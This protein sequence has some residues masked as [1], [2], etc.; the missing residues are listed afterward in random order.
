M[1]LHPHPQSH[2]NCA[3]RFTF[4]EIQLATQNLD[5]SLVIG[6]G[7][8]GKVYK[9]TIANGENLLTVAIKRLDA[10]SNQGASEF[11]AEVNML[12]KLRHCHLVSLIGYCNDGKEMILVYE[13]M[14][15]GTLEDHLHCSRI[16]LS[17][18]Q[19]LT[20]CI[21][22]ARG[23]DYLHTGTGI[24]HGVVHRDVKSSN[25]LLH[26]DWA[27][28]I[29]DFG[30]SKIC[31]KNQ[32]TTHVNTNVKG[33]FGYLD[34]DYFY[35]GKLTR[36]S[37]VYAFG[38]VLFEVLCGKRA[39]DRRIDEE[40]WGLAVWAQKSIK[41]GR[42][43]EIVDDNIR[44]VISP[45]CLKVFAEI[46]KRCLH[47]QPKQRPTMAEVVI[48]LESVLTL[49]EKANI[50]LQSTGIKFFASK[51]AKAIFL[52]NPKYSG[53]NQKLHRFDFDT[54][55][56]ATENFSDANRI[57]SL[58]TYGYLYKGKLQNGQGIAVCRT[59]YTSSYDSFMNE[60]SLVV[61]LEH[62][63][64]AKLLG[65]CYERASLI[66]VYESV[67][68]A[69]PDDL[70]FD[71]VGTHLDWDKRFK[72]IL[73]VA[74]ALLYL[75]SEAPIR[76]IHGDV[77]PGNILLD[78]NMN[79]VLSDYMNTR[80]E[81]YE[82][83]KNLHPTFLEQF[84]Y[85]APEYLPY[86]KSSTK[87]DV[88]SFGVLVLE[89]ITGHRMPDPDREYSIDGVKRA[90]LEVKTAWL[91]G[92]L[93]NII[94]PKVDVDPSYMTSFFAIGLLCVQADPADRPTMEE[95]VSMLLDSSALGLPVAKLQAIITRDSTS[96]TRVDNHN[97][98]TS[99][100]D[101]SFCTSDDDYDYDNGIV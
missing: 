12:S 1:R 71:P 26:D 63:N 62:E 74:R 77:K 36:K 54:I 2:H 14:S 69:T 55:I 75:H 9:G 67:L 82:T 5:E 38:V 90:W 33:T 22:A 94:Y 91:E 46:A 10:T 48:G 89:T 30:L 64:L 8:F 4:S 41:E 72:I 83:T 47:K 87:I 66:F 78:A 88:Y 56:V 79:P 80:Y 50:T 73:G 60:A 19:R 53:H 3:A 84:R 7:G 52:S 96:S 24:K 21:G 23:L 65:Y 93:S 61:K 45:K 39:V 85:I 57:R 76:I 95:V 86:A 99:D 29:S 6:R 92:T 37:D 25:I 11:W 97:C 20:I 34:P 59:N 70:M 18:M 58:K 15:H 81:D 42:L 17:W 49:Q 44:G 28:K 31:P 51:A 16:S 32:Q 40:Q 100:D 13:Y 35:T 68:H 98:N 43:K 27:A 101:Y